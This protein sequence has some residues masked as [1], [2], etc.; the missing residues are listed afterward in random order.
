[1]HVWILID[2]PFSFITS[3]RVVVFFHARHDRC[4]VE[5]HLKNSFFA[6]SGFFLCYSLSYV[7][8]I[9]TQ[10]PCVFCQF[11]AVIAVHI[12]LLQ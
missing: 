2:S 8:T 5:L 1:M 12:F 10:R 9:I 7:E 6:V 11:E 4:C 3:K